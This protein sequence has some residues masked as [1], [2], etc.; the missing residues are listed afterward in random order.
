V[1]YTLGDIRNATIK[2]INEYQTVTANID[3][4]ILNR[5]D[6]PINLY[7]Q[8]LALKDKISSSVAIPQFP[9]ENMLGEIFS[10]NTHTTTSVG[11]VA[12]SAYAY[13]YECD[14]PHSVDIME[15]SSTTTMTTLSTVTVTAA[16]TFIAYKNFVT[17]AVSSDYI[18]LNFYGNQE[19]RI[20]NVAFY[21]YTFGSSTA[22]I[23]SFK[24][25]V[26]YDLPSDYSDIN[27]VRYHKNS[28]Y[29]TFTDY[30]IDNKKLLISRGYSAEF[31]LDYWI[32]PPVVTT[33]TSAFLI[34]DRT[35]LIIPF[36]V[37][38]DVLIGNGVN[39]GQGQAFKTEYE[40]KRDKIDTST[41]HGKQTIN[42]TRGW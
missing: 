5:L 19:Y 9:V 28:D 20:Q 24:P 18:K 26:E 29:G 15:G 39:V 12:A 33:S 40:K 8:E 4:S 6:D 34:K 32:I 30:R 23:P 17:A 7:Y 11:Y 42:N 22:A 31:F 27:K 10:Y 21:P 37:A 35:T 38:G 16:S 3:I 13:Y 1:G 41:E 14:G 2:L 25:Y 36:G